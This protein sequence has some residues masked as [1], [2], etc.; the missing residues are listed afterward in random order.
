[1]LGC[2]GIGEQGGELLDQHDP[3]P[4]G[5]LGCCS[6]PFLPDLGLHL[7]KSNSGFK[8]CE[9]LGSNPAIL[10]LNPVIPARGPTA[11][12]AGGL[13]Q[14]KP[15]TEHPPGRAPGAG[16]VLSRGEQ[17]PDRSLHALQS[18]RPLFLLILRS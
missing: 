7:A 13:A 6:G 18:P 2:P 4:V 12:V 16:P 1:M 14:T 11:M 15:S 9:I 10:G 5:S 8:S 17:D 3:V